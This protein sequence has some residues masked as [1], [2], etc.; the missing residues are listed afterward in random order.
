MSY[1]YL[2]V[3]QDRGRYQHV[4]SLLKSYIINLRAK[5]IKTVLKDK[6]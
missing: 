5:K 3:E 4:V 2:L 1:I 6:V